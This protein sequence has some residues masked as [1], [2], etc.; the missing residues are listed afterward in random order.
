VGFILLATAFI[1]ALGHTQPPIQWVLAALNPGVKLSG[2][3]TNH[4][5]PSSGEV[6]N[7][8]SDIF[9]PT[10]VSMALYLFKYTIR[11][12]C[13]YLTTLHYLRLPNSG[14]YVMGHFVYK[15]LNTIQLCNV[16]LTKPHSLLDLSSRIYC[17]Q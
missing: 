17:L 12:H 15:A 8:R 11:L 9:I 1:P 7:A 4:S 16:R 10:Y 2:C 13:V 3:E 6:K 5:P 14:C